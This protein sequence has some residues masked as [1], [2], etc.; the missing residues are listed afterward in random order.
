[1]KRV[2]VM[3]M[4]GAGKSTFSQ[5]VG[6]VTGLPVIHLDVHYWRPGWEEPPREEWRETHRQLV[7]RGRWIIDGNYGSTIEERLDAADTVIFLEVSRY[8]CLFRILK[9]RFLGTNPAIAEGCSPK[10]DLEFLRLV[11]N[12]NSEKLPV[13]KKMAREREG[14]RV[15]TLGSNREREEF[16]ARL[17]SEQSV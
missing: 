14:T 9:R 11:W 13:R 2:A 3:G 6:E 10:V 12:F 1:M 5:R 16:L 17:D 4:S 8:V 15:V 7:D